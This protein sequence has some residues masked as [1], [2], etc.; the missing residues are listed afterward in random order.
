MFLGE[1]PVMKLPAQRG[2]PQAPSGCRS[3]PCSGL[4]SAFS[5]HEATSEQRVPLSLPPSPGR[6][7]GRPLA[8]AGNRGASREGILERF[9]QE[10]LRV[11]DV[12]RDRG[13][14]SGSVPP[15]V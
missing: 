7:R 12:S 9:F 13:P 6:P 5:T 2:E 4:S 8:W 14:G 15:S 3:R 1:G 11:A 10:A